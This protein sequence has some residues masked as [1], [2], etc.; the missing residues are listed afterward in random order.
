MLNK[1]MICAFC[2]SVQSFSMAADCNFKVKVINRANYVQEAS[3]IWDRE[4]QLGAG[5]GSYVIDVTGGYEATVIGGSVK[6]LSRI[7]NINLALVTTSIGVTA[8][9]FI[10][11]FKFTVIDK[12]DG[13]IFTPNKSTY[14][15]ALRQII[16]P[17]TTPFQINL[18][19]G[20]INNDQVL[21][22]TSGVMCSLNTKPGETQI[23]SYAFFPRWGNQ[24]ATIT[25]PSGVTTPLMSGGNVSNGV[26]E[27]SIVPYIKITTDT[28]QL[29]F[30]NIFP[31]T[32]K[33]L[34]VKIIID[35]NILNTPVNLS[36]DIPDQFGRSRIS[37]AEGET[38]DIVTS[39]PI[40]GSPTEI[41][42]HIVVSN[43]GAATGDFNWVMNITATIN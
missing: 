24:P 11:D 43:D 8:T 13:I 4:L 23:L 22:D 14:S 39:S 9:L 36:Y 32:E 16:S 30:G 15:S 41:T 7:A 38:N 29:S 31:N 33:T 26:I 34:P 28:T 12:A 18:W 40:N 5:K 20:L 1:F 35:T 19:G 6:A 10:P 27:W 17:D 37:I 42:R 21:A 25:Q 3:I 2:M